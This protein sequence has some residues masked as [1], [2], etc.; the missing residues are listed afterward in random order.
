MSGRV[1]CSTIGGDQSFSHWNRHA[2]LGSDLVRDEVGYSGS[3]KQR[4][5]PLVVFGLL[6]AACGGGREAAELPSSTT[7]AF[8][9][10]ELDDTP[11]TEVSTTE[12]ASTSAPTAAPT[13][14]VVATTASSTATASTTEEQ[15]TT[16]QDPGTVNDAEDGLRFDVGHI[17]SIEDI[18][19]V[20]F[21]QFDR[22]QGYNENLVLISGVE[23]QE[24]YIIG[25]ITD[26]PFINENPKL[27]SYPVTPSAQVLITSQDWLAGQDE[28]CGGD[29][30]QIGVPIEFVPTVLETG[31]SGV[32]ASLAFDNL[33][34]V[35]SLRFMLTC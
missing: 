12:P 24:E 33:G 23:L 3:A 11:E 8:V 26:W 19:G 17:T 1:W 15:T 27:R 18:D 14:A 31:L 16:E 25:A 34:W 2:E 5:V 20:T 32:V 22:Y 13:T 10:S 4:L 30:S 6:A 7:E 9:A 35:T 28:F 21:I 29:S